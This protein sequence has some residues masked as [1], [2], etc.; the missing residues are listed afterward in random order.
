MV[1]AQTYNTARKASKMTGIPLR[2]MRKVVE[3][4]AFWEAR[5]GKQFDVES[6]ANGLGRTLTHT[7]LVAR[8]EWAGLARL[9]LEDME[10]LRLGGRGWVTGV[11]GTELEG[12]R[13]GDAVERCGE[14][15]FAF[16]EY[17][18]GE[19]E[20]KKKKKKG[21]MGWRR[22]VEM[23]RMVKGW[24]KGGGGAGKAWVSEVEDEE[25]KEDKPSSPS[26]TIEWSLGLQERNSM[27]G[28][29]ELL[30]EIHE[31]FRRLGIPEAKLAKETFIID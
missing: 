9:L 6:D 18:E 17:K 12:L 5:R 21:E 7:H 10:D 24:R 26:R 31:R 20:K 4:Y 15:F 16:L 13:M 23:G 22:V 11:L 8:K 29:E 3:A 1:D 25:E 2:Q 14:R 27:D 19:K 30:R 28:E